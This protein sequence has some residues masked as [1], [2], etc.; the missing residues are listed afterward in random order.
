M[1]PKFRTC[2]RYAQPDNARPGPAELPVSE[3]REGGEIEGQDGVEF[4][5][6]EVQ[7]DVVEGHGWIWVMFLYAPYCGIYGIGCDEC[8]MVYER[9]GKASSELLVWLLDLVCRPCW[10]IY[11]C[12]E[13]HDPHSRDI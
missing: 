7:G 1:D 11:N 13:L 12:I 3:G 8:S 2:R 4:G 9:R 6:W 10:I 5:G